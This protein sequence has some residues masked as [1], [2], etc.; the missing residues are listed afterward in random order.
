[1][2]AP[3]RIHALPPRDAPTDAMLV[4]RA[5]A[6]DRWAEEA[7]YRRHVHRVTMV[8]ARLLRCRADVEDVVQD[9]FLGGFRELASLREPERL[10]SWLAASAVH[11]VHKIF[12]RRRLQRLFGWGRSLH[13][14]PLA[15]QVR[16]DASPETRAELA[17]LDRILDQLADD[18]RM[19][20]VL[21]HLLGHQVAEVAELTH[22]SLAT[23]HRRLARAHA[24]VEA[25]F[26]S[27]HDG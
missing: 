17:L 8:A 12:R 11:R 7:I 16:D 25:A 4:E 9:V 2:P 18:D 13:D 14:E 1:M 27:R 24:H 3:L 26:G 5:L 6:G 15:E 19:A 22:C 23:V 21:R 20:W 10:G